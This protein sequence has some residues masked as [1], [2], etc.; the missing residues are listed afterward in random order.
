MAT[1]GVVAAASASVG[2]PH[3]L[4]PPFGIPFG[5]GRV[6]S[7]RR[8]TAG[9]GPERVQGRRGTESVTRSRS[10]LPTWKGWRGYTGAGKPV[11]LQAMPRQ[12][13]VGGGE[14][15]DPKMLWGPL[16]LLSNPVDYWSRS[17]PTLES[18]E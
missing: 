10:S 7:K 12:P 11:D 5:D 15:V 14:Q 1:V 8:L 16:T 4:A 2:F 6:R 17:F 13:S 3:F 18:E 9:V